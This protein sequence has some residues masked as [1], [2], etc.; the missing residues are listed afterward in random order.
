MSKVITS[1][2][3]RYPGT[4]TISDPLTFPQAVAFE[5]A[6]GST[7]EGQG[8]TEANHLCVPGILKCAEEWRLANFPEQP[9]AD[10]WPATPRKSSAELIAWLVEEITEVYKEAEPDPNE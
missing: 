4:V 7:R 2:V 1:P 9:T 3:K 6:I 5:N 10:T 8:L